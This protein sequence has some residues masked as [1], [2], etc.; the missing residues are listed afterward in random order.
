MPQPLTPA[1]RARI[2]EL[3]AQGATNKAIRRE[4]GVDKT[5]AARYRARLGY[6]PAKQ[7][8]PA[9]KSPLTLTEKWHTLARPVEGGHM[10]W[11]GRHRLNSGTMV[12]THHGREYTARAVAFRI[13]TGRDPIGRVTAECD[14]PGCV[15]PQC[16]EDDP[17]RARHRA[18][19]AALVGR[20]TLLTECTAGHPTAVHRRYDRDGRPYCA[21]C[22]ALR[23]A[24]RRATA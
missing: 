10:E 24:R 1:T 22:H 17:G 15:A 7:P 13:R 6:G 4:L 19:F 3:L 20:A 14:R 9:N 2:A 21:A 12:L 16:V 11:T 8:T 18:Q 23:D 5:T